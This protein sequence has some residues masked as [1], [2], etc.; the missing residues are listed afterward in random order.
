MNIL[1]TVILGAVEG[2]TEFL[3]ISSTAHLVLA[4]RLLDISQTE[5]VKS[6]QIAIQLGAILAVVLLYWRKFF[7][8]RETLKRV[9]A[10]FVPTALIG[11]LLYRL[12]REYLV[13]NTPLIVWTLLV[14]GVFLILFE[15]FRTEKEGTVNEVRT[16]SYRQSIGIGLAQ[17]LAIVPGISRAG[18]TIVASMLFGLSRAASVEFSFLLAVPTM[19]AATGYDLAKTGASFSVGEFGTLALGFLVS[20]ITALLAVKFLLRYIQKNTFAGFGVYRILIALLF[21]LFFV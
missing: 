9:A 20:L 10:A 13:E 11:F 14:G 5:F 7:V 12:F 18:A 19:L 2:L 6:F 1:H 16:M 3:P 15:R 21:L 4:T 17:A 8:D